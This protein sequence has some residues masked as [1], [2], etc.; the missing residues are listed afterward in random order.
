MKNNVLMFIV[1]CSLGIIVSYPAFVPSH[2]LDSYCTM[3]NGY[4]DTASWFLQNGRVFSALLF[5]FYGL[6]NYPFDSMGYLSLLFSNV[7]LAISIVMLY[8]CIKNKGK[9]KNKIIDL[10]LLFGL[11]LIFYTPVYTEVLL[12]DEV[13]I[14]ALGILFIH[15]SIL[16]IH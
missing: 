9:F 3:Y 11:F 6:I 14:I 1:L 4:F 5:A 7:F 16:L 8:N 12:L 15:I 10:V 13:G 2:A